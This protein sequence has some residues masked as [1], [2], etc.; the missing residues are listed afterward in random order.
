MS[1]MALAI[2]TCDRRQFDT[3]GP[4]SIPR[5]NYFLQMWESML[6]GG[7][8]ENLEPGDSVAVF[9][10]GPRGLKWAKQCGKWT[11]ELGVKIWGSPARTRLDLIRNTHRAMAWI[12][13]TG[14]DYGILLSDDFIVCKN[15]FAEVRRWIVD[16]VPGDAAAGAL[17][18]RYPWT[19]DPE[20]LARRWAP[21]PLEH[22]YC[23][24]CVYRPADLQAY[25]L[26]MH[27]QGIEQ[28]DV[29]TDFI[30][31]DMARHSNRPIYAH[32]PDLLKHIGERSTLSHVH[33]PG[34]HDIMFPGEDYDALTGLPAVETQGEI[35]ARWSQGEH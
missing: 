35:M 23:A 25:L 24:I 1:S 9:D 4:D 12:V 21:Y 5:E 31:R 7:L 27:R 14:C 32:C 19:R 13:T 3:A 22:F 29:G 10:A 17:C 8:K 2:I 15:W 18:A 16:D 33:A 20:N 26:S 30:P 28:W 11:K 6:K 34:P